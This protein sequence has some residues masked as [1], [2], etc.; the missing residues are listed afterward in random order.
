MEITIKMR[1]NDKIKASRIRFNK[2]ILDTVSPVEIQL[3]AM[4][5]ET[6]FDGNLYQNYE[7]GTVD[8]KTIDAESINILK[9]T[10][11]RLELT[12]A[13]ITTDSHM[14]EMDASELQDL[15][16]LNIQYEY[17]YAI[18]ESLLYRY[19]HIRLPIKGTDLVFTR[20]EY[21]QIA[22]IIRANDYKATA[23]NALDNCNSIC[24]NTA[25][26][27]KK[28]SNFPSS[29]RDGILNCYSGTDE[30]DVIDEYL[31]EHYGQEITVS[32][33]SNKDTENEIIQEVTL[34]ENIVDHL[35][36]DIRE[37][38]NGG[39]T[40]AINLPEYYDDYGD[41]LDLQYVDKIIKN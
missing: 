11:S 12:A 7:V 38:H 24:E 34:P 17:T 27:L 9:K 6:A 36:E 25:Q 41:L 16:I 22:D 15:D 33:V 5:Y 8:G 35:I 39:S 31:Y 32:F 10:W 30:A 14:E 21:E 26:I 18:C 29:F 1:E 4:N 23:M 20:Y 28:D 13:Y 19:Q 2:L 3:N 40:D 37:M